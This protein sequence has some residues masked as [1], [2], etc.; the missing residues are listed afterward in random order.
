M[1]TTNGRHGS[2]PYF[3]VRG[4][5]EAYY[6]TYYTHIQRNDLIRFLGQQGFNFYLYGPKNDRSHRARWREPY[7]ESVMGHF[8]HTVALA[9]SVGVSFCYTLS[10]AE[11]IRFTDE[12][13]FATLTARLRTFYQLGV[14]AFGLLFDDIVPV[15][16]QE[17]DRACF[18]TAAHAQAALANR[19]YA[20]LQVLDPACTLLCCPV[21][22]AGIAPF[23]T[24]LH[25]LAEALHPAIDLFY[26]GPA[27]CTPT[28][29][30]ADVLAFTTVTGR[31]PILWDNYPVNDLAMTA[32]LHLGPLQGREVT[33][34]AAT[35][36]YIANLMLQPAASRIPLLTVAE[37]VADP[38]HYDPVVA[39]ERALQT[40][41]GADN[42]AALRLF[43]E[44]SLF[45]VLDGSPPRLLSHLA[46]EA[47]AALQ[48]GETAT[49]STAVH[50]LDDYLSRLDE[51]CYHL[52]YYLPDLAL[53]YDLLPWLELLDYWQDMARHALAALCAWEH[54][55]PLE[56]SLQIAHEWRQ[57]VARHP[58]RITG[59]VLLPLVDYVLALVAK[60]SVQLGGE[61]AGAMSIQTILEQ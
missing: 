58:C 36:G 40:I 48:R 16:R 29:T 41:G 34:H 17:A 46:D 9:R 43:A 52:K 56:R 18:A 50:S 51:A 13:D 39:W 1:A 11:T 31:V 5:A 7:P 33:L 6:G 19:V 35:K 24:G 22:Y 44:N 14:R 42:V 27:T 49:E 60:P 45:S 28:I 23:P 21:E 55:H 32:E 57:L 4:V 37:Y 15:L 10:P 47:L 12:T 20:W 30:T 25:V 53:R 8:A 54:G 38:Y 26:T 2:T 61:G 59:D 3:R